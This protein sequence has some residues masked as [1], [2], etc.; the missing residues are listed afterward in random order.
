M[1]AAGLTCQL[2]ILATSSSSW[3]HPGASQDDSGGR[4]VTQ[5]GG[6]RQ[7]YIL[8]KW[9]VYYLFR[10]LVSSDP[11]HK[12]SSS[13]VSSD[14]ASYKAKP[15]LGNIQL[16]W[17]LITYNFESTYLLLHNQDIMFERFLTFLSY[18]PVRRVEDS[19]ADDIEPFLPPG[20]DEKLKLS[21]NNSPLPWMI[22]TFVLGV[23]L[24]ASLLMVY[25]FKSHASYENGFA[26]DM[27]E[28]SSSW[29]PVKY[30]LTCWTEAGIQ[31]IETEEVQFTGGIKVDQNGSFYMH[32]NPQENARYVGKPTKEMDEAW[33]RLTGSFNLISERL[34]LPTNIT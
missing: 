3:I 1:H 8:T 2:Q 25:P 34:Y 16:C 21:S 15:W 10:Y 9:H 33:D 20:Y 14:I 23:C 17:I 19:F 22:S 32:F 5:A 7:F 13:Q 26:T 12:S 28:F 29:M 31:I 30:I 18:R 6:I 11:P 27:R 24:L 4:M